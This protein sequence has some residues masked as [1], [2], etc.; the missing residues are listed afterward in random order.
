MLSLLASILSWSDPE[1]EQAGLQRASSSGRRPLGA[2]QGK[3]KEQEEEPPSEVGLFTISPSQSL[4]EPHVL[5]RIALSLSP[6]F[7]SNSYCAKPPP[8][9]IPLPPH[10]PFLRSHRRLSP[11]HHLVPLHPH[12]TPA[13]YSCPPRTTDPL[14]PPST[15]PI[16]PPR[17]RVDPRPSPLRPLRRATRVRLQLRRVGRRPRCRTRGGLGMR[18]SRVERHRGAARAREAGPATSASPDLDLLSDKEPHRA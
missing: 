17:A 12:P 7:S 10:L 8:A 16:H 3:A 14:P 2:G 1:R 9:P 6:P 5:S 13:P 15:R 11:V 4:A 18:T